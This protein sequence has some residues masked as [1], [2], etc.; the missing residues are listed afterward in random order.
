MKK[1]AIVIPIYK[2]LDKIDRLEEINFD[3]FARFLDRD[4]ENYDVI[5]LSYDENIYNS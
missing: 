3:R 2:T 1:F 5:C 4:S